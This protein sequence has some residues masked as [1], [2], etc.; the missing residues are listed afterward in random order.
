MKKLILIIGA[1]AA[2]AIAGPASAQYSGQ[3]G[4]GYRQ[5]NDWNNRS[6]GF[7]QFDQQYRH[8]MQGIRH[9]LNDGTY[10][11]SRANEFFRELQSIRR[12]AYRAQQ[13]GNYR[14]DYVQVR[15]ARL[16]E[17]MHRK[18]DR[19]HERNDRY[20]QFDRGN[21]GYYRANEA[22]SRHGHHD[23]HDDDDD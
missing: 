7:G 3:Y 9:G 17:R 18:H 6:Q 10:S 12:D 14:D 5:T 22:N 1:G 13:Y 4:G 20:G 19:A 8:T 11:R 21:S 15:M 16:H 23:N 2:V